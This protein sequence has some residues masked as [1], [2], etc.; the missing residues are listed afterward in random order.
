MS[1][2]WQPWVRRLI[3]S[4]QVVDYRED[5][6]HCGVSK[7]LDQAGDQSEALVTN[8]L[9][10]VHFLSLISNEEGGISLMNLLVIVLDKEITAH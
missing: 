6:L 4:P 2:A 5:S 9:N 1:T 7:D 3:A 8:R 10:S